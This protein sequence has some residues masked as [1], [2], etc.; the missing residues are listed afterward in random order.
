[1]KKIIIAALTILL[2]YQF[3]LKDS[4]ALEQEIPLHDQSIYNG[5]LILINKGTKLQQDPTNLT[6]IPTALA[7][8]VLVD[9]EY[10]VAQDILEPLRRMF[11][12]AESDGIHHFKINSAYRS[13]KLQQQL[14][15]ENGG[16]Y[17]LPSGYSEHQ[18]GLSVDIGSTQGTMENANEGKWLAKHAVD[19]GFILRYPANKVNVTGIAF[20]PWHFRYVGLPHSVIM[21][22]KDLALE[23]Y[24]KFLKQEKKYT[25]KFNGVNYFVQYVEKNDV[26]KIPDTNN[27]DIS[28][29]NQNG[30]IVTSVVN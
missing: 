22:Q 17:A 29:D 28:G 13:G 4:P 21:Q 7:N 18:T 25:K 2:G 27:F 19:F 11:N 23:E 30:F 5:E 16:D 10:W 3:F 24:I 20:E 14:Y 9:S 1:M 6:M 26:I 12:A 15:E 8:N